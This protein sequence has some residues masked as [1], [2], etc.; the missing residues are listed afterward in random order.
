[1]PLYPGWVALDSALVTSNRCEVQNMIQLNSG[2]AG[3]CKQEETSINCSLR[4]YLDKT[5]EN[6][7]NCCRSLLWNSFIEFGK[8]PLPCLRHELVC[9]CAFDRNFTQRREIGRPVKHTPFNVSFESKPT[10]IRFLQSIHQPQ[11]LEQEG[12]S[13]KMFK[14]CGQHTHFR[15]LQGPKK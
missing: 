15:T 13:S 3:C 9:G 14:M 5:R 1:M 8:K 10:V 2:A 7:A 6:H 11:S 4:C 12:E